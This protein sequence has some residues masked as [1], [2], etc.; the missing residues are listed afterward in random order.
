[1]LNQH[2]KGMHEQVSQILIAIGRNKNPTPKPHAPTISITTRSGTS[3][4]DPPYPTLLSPTT[5]DHTEGTVKKGGP[6]GGKPTVA[7]S[8]ETP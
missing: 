8:E 5:I 6:K 3:T 1:M 7:R 2:R 4:H